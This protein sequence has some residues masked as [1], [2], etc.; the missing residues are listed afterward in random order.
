MRIRFSFAPA[1][2][3]FALDANG[4]YCICV[5][6]HDVDINSECYHHQIVFY[7]DMQWKLQ[8]MFL[9]V[10]A[11]TANWAE[12]KWMVKKIMSIYVLDNFNRMQR[13]LVCYDCAVNGIMR[14]MEYMKIHVS[15]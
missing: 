14:Q 8:R 4:V 2:Q 6:I 15:E 10:R 7:T 13:I 11:H 9:F 12:K 5:L 1:T 3:L